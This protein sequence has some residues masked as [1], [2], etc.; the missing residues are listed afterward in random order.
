MKQSKDLSSPT[1]SIIVPYRDRKDHLKKFI[2]H[3]TRL[4]PEAEIIIVEQ[5]DS[6]PFNRGK[7]LNIGALHATTNHFIFHDVD[8]LVLSGMNHYR[9]V[10]VIPT[11]LAT[12][13]QQ[14]GYQLPFP[15]YF[16]G[17][18]AF[19]KEQFERV[20]GFCNEFWGWG[21]E[22]CE[23]FDN[24]KNYYPIKHLNCYH[25]SLSHARAI[26]D[27]I[28]PETHPNYILWKQGRPVY[29]GLQNTD[30]QIESGAYSGTAWHIKVSI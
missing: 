8:L 24:V 9:R 18:V 7:L 2:P 4:F 26:D 15:D 10:P 6:K 21:G 25:E 22:D 16:G 11:L 12:H 13:L 29:S 28:L 17:V 14:F 19:T 5:L 30:Y 27:I 20:D 23:M 1:F 3:Y